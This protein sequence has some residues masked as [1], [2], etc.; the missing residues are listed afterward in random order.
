MQ[1]KERIM[2]ERK[3]EE[4]EFHD[5]L[6]ANSF[7]QRW[8]P[9][10]EKL[11]KKDPLWSNMKYYSIERKSRDF[12]LDW[13]LLNCH[14]KKVLDYCCGNGEDA[15]F[16]AKNGAKE[17]IG[18]D[19]SGV[20]IDNCNIRATQENVSNVVSFRVM[21][22]EDLKFN[23]NTFDVVTEYGC[24]HHIDLKKA[25]SEIARVLKPNGKAICNEALG[26]NVFIRLYRK[27][28]PGLRTK[29]EAEHILKKKDIELAKRHFNKVKCHFFHLFTL[30][31]VPFRNLPGFAGLL[32]LMEYLDSIILKLPILKWQAWQVVLVLSEPRGK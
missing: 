11:I 27:L 2:D 6:R 30:L 28:T 12:V 23:D 10:L 13:L 19:I 17:I 16:V 7:D 15:I 26:H 22:A 20:S 24:L 25:Y 18:M 21:D 14:N 29:Y 4:K 8:S 31:S 32:T 5:K 9:D 1:E 3:R